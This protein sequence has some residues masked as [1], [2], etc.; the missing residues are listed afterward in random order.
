MPNE[1]VARNGI[2]ALNNSIITGSLNVTQGVTA[3]LFGTASWS[4]NTVNAISSSYPVA[5]SGSTVYTPTNV[6]DFSTTFSVLVGSSAG[7]GSTAA[8]YSNF[9]GFQAGFQATS[10][11]N[12][13]FLGAN[14]GYSS[15]N[16]AFSTFIGQNSGFN[17]PNATYSNFL[18][19]FAGYLSTNASYS[20]FFGR[21]AGDTSPGASYSNFLGQNA[22][23]DAANASYSNFLGAESGRNS[24]NALHSNF[25]GESAGY[26]AINASGSNFLGRSAG[27]SASNAQNS[28][29]LGLRAGNQANQASASNFIG[30]EAGQAAFYADNSNFIGSYA[31]WYA[32]SASYSTFLGYRAGYNVQGGSFGVKSNN[33]IIGTNI[34]LEDG[35]QNSINIGGFI[36]GTGSYSSIVG[37]PFSGSVGNGRVGINQPLPLYNLD[38]SGSARFTGEVVLSGSIAAGSITGSLLGTASFAST[39]SNVLGGGA[40][41][42]PLWNT[43]TSLSSSVMYQSSGNLGIGT[44]SPTASLHVYKGLAGT[45]TADRT[46]PLDVLVIESENT[47]QTEFDGFGQSIVFRGSTYNDSTQRALGKI[48]HQIRD[49]S[50]NTTRGSSLNIQ[51][52]TGSTGNTLASRLYIDYNGNV[53][54]GTTTPN[55]KLDVNGNAIITGS[56]TVTGTITAQTL[57]VQT[58]TSSVSFITG[59]T[60]FGSTL[61]NTHQF[62]GSVGVTGSLTVNNSVLSV[63]GTNVGI[64]TTSPY[65]KFTV[66]GAA[67]TSTSQISIVNSEGGHAI[68]RSGV[69][70]VT[71]NGISFVTADV[72]GSNQNVRAVISSA[73]NVGI[74][75]TAPQTILHAGGSTTSEISVGTTNYGGNNN[76]ALASIQSDQSSGTSGGILYIKTNPWNNSSGLGLYSPITRMTINEL[77]NVGIGLTSPTARLHVTASTGGVLEVDGAGTAGAN[78]LYVSASGNVGLGINSPGA[79]LEIAYTT[80]P[81]TA[82]PH[83]ILSTGG[84]VKQAAITAESFAI[85]GLVFSTGD[86]T[87]TD[88]MTILRTNGNVGIGTTSPDKK[89]RVTAGDIKI[90]NNY[91]YIIGDTADADG[92]TITSDGATNNMLIAQNNN[93]YIKVVTSGASGDIRFFPNAVEQVIF[94][95]SGNVGIGTTAPDSNLQVGSISTSGNRTIK[96]TDS[97]YGLLLSGGGGPTSNYI[98]SIGTT[99]P[100]YFLAGNS[101][102]ANYIFSSTG[103]VGVGLTNPTTKLHV[104]ASTGGVLEVDGAGT[105]G[106]NALYV[107]ASGNVGVGTVSPANKLDINNAN[108]TTL[109]STGGGVNLNYNTSTIGEFATIGFSWESS[110]D[111]AS[112]YGMGFT[113]TN[114]A[115]GQ[116]DL[117]LYTNGSRRL[118]ITWDGNVG[119]NTTTPTNTL[120]VN[121]TLNVR[122]NYAY[123]GGDANTAVYAGSFSNE[124]R[125]GVGGRSTIPTA[126]L[127]FFT[128]EG[129]NNIERM[130]ITSAGDV[131]I[132]TTTPSD[133]LGV[134]VDINAAAGINISNQNTGSSARTRLAL[135]TQGG[136]WYLDG[137]RTAGE[138]AI[139]RGSTE[140]LRISGAGNVGIGTTSPNAKLDVSGSAIVSGSFTVSPSNAVE[141]QVTSTGTKIGNIITDAHTIT[142]SLGISGSAVVIGSLA[143]GTSSL[144]STENTIVVGP[145]PAG[146]TGEGGQI[147]LQAPGGSYTS[148]SMIDNYQNRFRILRGTNASSDAEYFNL[149]LHSGQLGFSKYTGSGA[150]P[151]TAVANLAVDSSGNVITVA[152]GGGGGSV[153]INNNTDNYLIT[154]TGT[155][156]TLNGEANLQFDGSTLTVTGS[157]T[158][159]TGSS[160]EF[161]VTNTGV[162]IGNII[163]DI[164][165]ITGSLNISGSV[166][167]SLFGTASYATQALS[168]SWAPGGGGGSAPT[169]VTFNRV[170]GSYTFALTDAGK[171]VEV[172]GSTNVSHSLTI[173]ASSSVDFADGTYIDVILYGTGSILF[174]TGSGV[175]I[176]SANSWNRIGTRY[177]AATLINISGNEWYL[178]GNINA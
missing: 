125:I 35:R 98:S 45:T 118:N 67:S 94:K 143:I 56:L 19:R 31:G 140:V 173:P 87:L 68:I 137:V 2:I 109:T 108:R 150:F 18:G 134:V 116:G 155:A 95:A 22:G 62:T 96:I 163:S 176:R 82:T 162:R 93:A 133:K 92:I 115:S 30:Y 113:G 38:V 77:G 169:A 165:T 53:G 146:G 144:G 11:N 120:D 61:S 142:G 17:A 128:A 106:A 84:T 130:R 91:K 111:R 1:F 70:G 85:S 23:R 129:T 107:S 55:A 24:T 175:T 123:F 100:L 104:S 103:N 127:T 5:L 39:A 172:S 121:G 112:R 76:Q 101:N 81:T 4:S 51:L 164:H 154:A 13:N 59:S 75:T 43:A 148:A 48:I 42:I 14:A 29:F 88:R 78:A 97:G 46:T 8:A 52:A 64:G 47:A 178:I 26:Q 37:N 151:G 170:T 105:A 16:A 158:V 132:G 139:T 20:N 119:I 80:N 44:T 21:S 79:K 117:F 153:T 136:N 138:F 145:P 74:G 49:D 71:N 6:G 12:S 9:V 33:I 124:G 122:S 36:F 3:S 25:L 166:T 147:L 156:N 89:L 160:I 149:S 167:G 86:G 66:L 83:I 41:Y 99:I 28:N 110:N 15:S 32:A 34:T 141:L 126:A 171:T 168:A 73:G 58:V 90:S 114:F 63:G 40:S 152:T 159:I 27:Y 10:A 57:V 69:A 174:A 161:Q 72:D 102:D 65:S 157:L 54:I 131:G 50:V 177:G 7:S 60:R 135:E